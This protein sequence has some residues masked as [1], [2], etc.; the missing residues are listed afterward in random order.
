M[1]PFQGL[2]SFPIFLSIII[3]AFQAFKS[4]KDDI[5]IGYE[6]IKGLITLKGCHSNS[7]R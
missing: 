5:I 4:R 3:S 7:R 2:T 1:S 6:Q